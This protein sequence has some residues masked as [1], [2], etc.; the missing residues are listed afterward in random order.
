MKRTKL[1]FVLVA[2]VALSVGFSSCGRNSLVGTT[3]VHYGD[4]WVVNIVFTTETS[5]ILKTVGG[6][7]DLEDVQAFTYTFNAPVITLTSFEGY[8]LPDP[9]PFIGEVRGSKMTL[10]LEEAGYTIFVRQ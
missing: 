7:G 9:N 3:W 4:G 5:G 6:Y 8:V 1:F 10:R 2:M